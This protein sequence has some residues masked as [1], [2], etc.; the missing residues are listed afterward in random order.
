[1]G[2]GSKRRHERR[3][4]VLVAIDDIAKD[5]IHIIEAITH[6]IDA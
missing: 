6:C 3:S 1:V 5:G 2:L 4:L